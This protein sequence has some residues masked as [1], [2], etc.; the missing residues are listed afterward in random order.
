MAAL[1][2]THKTKQNIKLLEGSQYSLQKLGPPGTWEQRVVPLPFFSLNSGQAQP[3]HWHQEET[4]T[5]EVHTYPGQD[6][7]FFSNGF[8]WGVELKAA[9]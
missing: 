3:S 8:I 9:L 1:Q 5:G 6:T 7:V 2:T 4:R